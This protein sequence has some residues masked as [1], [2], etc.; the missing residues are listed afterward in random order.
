MKKIN[1]VLRLLTIFIFCVFS[2]PSYGQERYDKM[3]IYSQYGYVSVLLSTGCDHNENYIRVNSP[4]SFSTREPNFIYELYNLINE[5]EKAPVVI[6]E[7]YHFMCYLVVDFVRNDRIL[8][9][10]GFNEY[11]QY[12][13]FT[14]VLSPLYE[15]NENIVKYLKESFPKFLNQF[16]K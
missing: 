16:G 6:E 11:G 7:D 2:L 8:Y 10:A 14:G 13:I 3:I 9:S 12:R 5:A 15:A 4:V 1:K